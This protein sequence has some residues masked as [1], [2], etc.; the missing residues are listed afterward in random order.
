VADSKKMSG[1]A[2]MKVAFRNRK[3]G[4]MLAFG[5]SA[6]LPNALLIGTLFAWLGAEK[7]DLGTMGV[8]SLIGLAYSFKFLWSPL[9]DKVRIPVLERLG[10]RRSWLLPIQVLLAFIFII[11]SAVSPVSA[12]G[13]FS[14]MAGLGAIASATQDIVID[15][16]RVEVA[17]EQSPLEILSAVYQLGYRLATLLGGAVALILAE[18]IGW[19]QVFLLAGAAMFILAGLTLFAPDTQRPEINESKF[20]KAIGNVAPKLR[21]IAIAIVGAAWVWALYIII[22]FMVQSLGADPASR[23]DAKEF[24]KKF[25]PLIVIATVIL[26]ALMAAWINNKVVDTAQPIETPA[27]APYRLADQAYSALLLPLAEIIGRLRWGAVVALGVILTYRLTDSV[28][29]PFAY[30]FYLEELKYTNDQVAFASKF[31]GVGMTMLGITM[32]AV[33]FA[34]IGRMATLFVGAI[35]ASASNLLYADLA[36]GGIGIDTFGNF[37]GIYWLAEQFGSDARYSRLLIAISGENLAS[38]IAGAAFVAY[39]SSITSKEYSIVQYAL[40]SSLT[41]LVGS[42]GRGALG[43]TIKSDGYAYIFFLTAALGIVAIILCLFEWLRN[44]REINFTESQT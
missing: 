13:L 23:P 33:S 15:G 7:V 29:G 12:L 17:D 11:M 40:L 34:T 43:E 22:H 44:K 24:T 14:F 20:Y 10:R 31:F 30:P 37:T 3:T 2:L 27:S 35:L 9:I 19:P 25:A 16:W 1:F 39:L 28:W 36:L 8:L 4:V 42:L 41:S 18:R 32:G 26:P 6:G 21:M 5:V 38:G